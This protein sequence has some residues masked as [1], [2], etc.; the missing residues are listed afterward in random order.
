VACIRSDKFQTKS[1]FV[2]RNLIFLLFPI[3]TFAQPDEKAVAILEKVS[4]TNGAY[5]NIEVAFEYTL[6]NAQANVSDTREGGLLLAGERFH[7]NLMGQKISSDG[8]IVWYDM[9]DEVHIKNMSEFMEETDLDPRNIFTQYNKGFKHKYKGERKVNGKDC[10]VVDLYPEIPGKKPFSRIELCIDKST[11]HIMES[12][13][14]GKDGT[15]YVLSVQNM[16]T[17]VN[18]PA[19]RFVFHQKAFEAKGYDVVDFR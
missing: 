15:H 11:N 1:S 19:D 4:A 12:T 10:H 14:F 6:S 2:V 3:V 18:L 7:L 17:N 9:D 13:T 5:S 16:K 8:Q